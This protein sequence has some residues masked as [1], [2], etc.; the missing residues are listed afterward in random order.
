M[1]VR[2]VTDSTSDI[3]D[4]LARELDITIIPVFLLFGEE[5]FRDRIDMSEDE[6]AIIYLTKG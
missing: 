5:T 4:K 3:P 6:L 2:I 1:V